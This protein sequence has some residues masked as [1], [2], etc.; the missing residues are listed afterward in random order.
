MRVGVVCMRGGCVCS[1]LC[2]EL[3]PTGCRAISFPGKAQ[4]E[5]ARGALLDRA[6]RRDDHPE[7]HGLRGQEVSVEVHAG[8]S[9][10]S[11]LCIYVCVCIY[12]YTHIIT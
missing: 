10:I 12:I 9:W 6:H 3:N 2:A 11:T 8:P 1:L 7:H 5:G 4:Q